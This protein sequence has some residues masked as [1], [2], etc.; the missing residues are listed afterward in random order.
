MSIPLQHFKAIHGYA[1]L[2][3][4]APRPYALLAHTPVGS[5]TLHLIC[6]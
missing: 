1:Y 5:R 2:E 4:T 6:A 3:L